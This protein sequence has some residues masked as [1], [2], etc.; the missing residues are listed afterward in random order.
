MRLKEREARKHELQGNLRPRD[1]DYFPSVTLL[2]LLKLNLSLQGT[3]LPPSIN[4]A[5]QPS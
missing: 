2:F 4:A 5:S 1:G 3:H